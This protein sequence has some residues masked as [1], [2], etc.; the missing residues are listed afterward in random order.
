MS[1]TPQEN[2]VAPGGS[3]APLELLVAAIRASN[4]DEEHPSTESQAKREAFYNLV[5]MAKTLPVPDG[6]RSLPLSYFIAAATGFVGMRNENPEWDMDRLVPEIHDLI[7]SSSYGQKFLNEH[8]ATQYGHVFDFSNQQNKD[9]Q[10]VTLVQQ[11]QIENGQ[12]RD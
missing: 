7:V 12:A 2:A 6:E 9:N 11:S 5:M 1:N 3:T 8:M 4:L 10:L